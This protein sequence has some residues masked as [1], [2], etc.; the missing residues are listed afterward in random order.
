MLQ[1]T[2]GIVLRSIKY[3]ETS[4]IVTIF[5]ELYGILSYHAQGVRKSKKNNAGLLQPSLLLILETD[6]KPNKNLQHL[7]SFHPA[8]FYQTIQEDVIKNSIAIFSAELLLRLL[9]EQAEHPDLFDFCFNYFQL[10]D[11]SSTN[12]IANFPLYF[13][14]KTG[15]FLGYKITG[16]YADETPYL[17]IHNGSFSSKE[18]YDFAINSNEADIFSTLIHATEKEF[19]SIKLSSHTRNIFTDWYIEFLRL[20]SQHLGQIKSL[21]V[22][23]AILH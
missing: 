13:L 2:K 15:E 5:T 16:K 17:D 1:T 6:H 10:L 4:L 20:H 18:T 22:L 23:R 8:F 21:E 12:E 11:R 3:G 14:V 19:F 9:P 7:R